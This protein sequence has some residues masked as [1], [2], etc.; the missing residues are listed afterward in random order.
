MS[1]LLREC[2]EELAA[3]VEVVRLTGVY[4]SSASRDVLRL[5]LRALAAPPVLSEGTAG[6]SGAGRDPAVITRD[7]A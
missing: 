3:A 4:T 7:C 1:G 2:M 5:P 6:V